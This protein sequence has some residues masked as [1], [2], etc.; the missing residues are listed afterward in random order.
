MTNRHNAQEHIGTPSGLLTV[1]EVAAQWG[2]SERTVRAWI[3][4]GAIT[5]IRKGGVV[6]I[7]PDAAALPR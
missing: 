4:K 2:V 3:D 1:R 5:V 7:V 6:R